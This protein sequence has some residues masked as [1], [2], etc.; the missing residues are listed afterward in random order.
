MPNR[1][2]VNLVIVST[3]ARTG[4]NV[5]RPNVLID[6]TATR[7]VT[8]WQQLRGRAMRALRTW[9][10]ECYRASV[11]LRTGES[12]DGELPVE[13]ADAATHVNPEVRERVQT[14]GIER[15]SEAEREALRVGLMLSRNKV[16]H[17]YELVKAFGGSRQVEYDRATRM[18]RRRESIERKHAY[19]SAVDPLS[20]ELARGVAH[21][22]LVYH[23][24][25]RADLPDQLRDRVSDVIRDRDAAIVQGWLRAA[26]QSL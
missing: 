17:I 25:P 18:W 12:V 24:D 4:W 8:A 22:P 19:E 20:G 7:D 21:A 9:T 11:V 16:T 23:A 26:D 1:C 5:I 10:N 6:A 14:A 13:I 3:W 15:L 2:R